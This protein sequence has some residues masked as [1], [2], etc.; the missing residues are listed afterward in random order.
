MSVSIVIPV[1]NAEKYLRK[2]LDSVCAQADCVTEIILVNDGSTDGSLNVCNEYAQKDGRI[3]IIDKQNEGAE[4]A[5]IDGVNA[6]TGEYVGFVDSDDYI[7]LTMFAELSNAVEQT[8]ADIA[9]CDYDIVDEHYNF[10]NKRDFAISEDGVY[11]KINGRFAFPILPSMRSRRFISGSRWNKLIKRSC[12][13]ENIAF[14]RQ[15]IRNGEDIA[16][17]IPIFMAVK[18][19]VYVKQCL[20]HY[21]QLQGSV[22]HVYKEQNLLDWERIVDILS[23]ATE[24]YDYRH[25]AFT[26]NC[27][28]LLIRT[29]VNPLRRSSLTRKQRKK[30]YAR[31][32]RNEKIK[33]LLRGTKLKTYAGFKKRLFFFLLKHKL[34]GLLSIVL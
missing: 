9:F 3:K 1:Y 19:V 20:Y 24:M 6:T 17:I 11:E 29:T 30:E 5:I 23:E 4:Q 22:S 32:G 26:N 34:Y 12:I 16:L 15:Q 13:V 21:V 27:L 31:I 25:V 10:I 14:R 7:E 2:C 28:E 8:N 33:Q 18:K